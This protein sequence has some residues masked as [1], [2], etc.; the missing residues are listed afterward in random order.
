M[1]IRQEF[2]EFKEFE[3]LQEFKEREPG[4]T[5]GNI[6]HPL[7]FKVISSQCSVISIFNENRNRKT[8]QFDH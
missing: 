8:R 6:E 3:E 7:C 5:S 4:A 2:E 1:L